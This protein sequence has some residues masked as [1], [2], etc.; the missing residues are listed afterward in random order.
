[1]NQCALS[2]ARLLCLSTL[3]WGLSVPLQAQ[4]VSNGVVGQPAVGINAGQTLYSGVLPPIVLANTL[5]LTGSF[6]TL[7]Q[8]GGI[9]QVDMPVLPVTSL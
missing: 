5:T 1:M 8:P 9:R 3:A 7:K 2:W 6:P 4:T